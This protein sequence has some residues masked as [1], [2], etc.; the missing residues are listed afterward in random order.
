MNNVRRLEYISK[1]DGAADDVLSSEGVSSSIRTGLRKRFGA[2]CKIYDGKEIPIKVIDRVSR[3][4]R[5]CIYLT[6][7]NVKYVPKWDVP[8]NIIYEDEDLAVIDKAAGI[9]VIP[10]KSHYGRSLANALA[11]LWGDF[12]YRPVNR[13]DRDTSGL[14]IVAKNQLA[15]SLLSASHIEREYIALCEGTFSGD[16][17]GVIDKPI[18]RM[19]NGMK[20]RVAQDG[21][22]AVTRYRVSKQYDGYFSCEFSLETGRTHQIRVHISYLGY[23][24]CC[25]RLYNPNCRPIICPNGITLE[26]QAL[27]SQR[28]SFIHPIDGR[29]M[30]FSSRPEFL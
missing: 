20:R 6:D 17:T 12:V 11:S 18:Q 21:D 15:H 16:K 4:E 14:M 13:L 10:R 7:E 28:I 3:G 22:R 9:A 25:D 29:R 24:L 5:I 8:V 1:F 23:P 2:V 26:R 27:H 30:E 19:E